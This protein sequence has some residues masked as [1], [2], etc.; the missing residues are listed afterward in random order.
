MFPEITR[1][2]IFRLETQRLWLRWPRAAD[3][4]AVTR[5]CNDPEVALKTTTIPYPYSQSDAER[6]LLR[7]R[8]ENAEGS[9]LHLALALKR[10]PNEPI[11]MISLMGAETRGE[12]KL[13][14]VLARDAWGRGFMTEAARA[15]VDLVFNLT[16]LDHV[17]SSALPDNAASLRVQEKLG[18]VVT[19]EKT[20]HAPARGGPLR[21]TA[22]LLK[23]GAARAPYGAL[24]ARRAAS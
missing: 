7:A 19:G 1:D 22:T 21:M 24:P 14:F 12:G 18:F 17:V 2:D 3:A 6:F 5:F 10:Q 8:S 20:T 11:G 15:F 23:R 9:A 13:G 16:S 4:V